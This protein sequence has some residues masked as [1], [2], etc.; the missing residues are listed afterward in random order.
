MTLPFP[1]GGSR[2]ADVTQLLA[3]TPYRLVRELGRGVAGRV[4]EIEHEFLGRR[5]ALKVLHSNNRESTNATRMRV[6]AQV[7]G[8][9]QHPN[10]VEVVD[11]WVAADGRPC[12]VM[13]LLEGSTLAARLDEM[14]QLLAADVV[15][16]AAQTLSALVTAHSLGVVHRD[17]KPE[18]LFLH[19]PVS[20]ASTV[21]KVLDFGLVRVLPHAALGTGALPALRT[22]TGS[23]VGSPQY[24]SPE[25]RAGERVDARA[26]LYSLGVILYV[27][28][29]GS[30]PFDETVGPPAAPSKLRVDGEPSAL[31][32]LVLRA[33]APR[34]EDRFQSADEFLE[35]LAPL[36]APAP[37]RR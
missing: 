1:P 25:A 23:L 22:K 14:P 9:I 20:G 15:E 18:N 31:D 28:L 10:V 32:A 12:I 6:E 3:A 21:V 19:V 16:L 2:A 11:F 33:I 35:A 7:L 24:M 34:I 30:G 27:G 37:R 26:D 4:Y 5:L 29:T 17:L 36:R 8:R 13:E